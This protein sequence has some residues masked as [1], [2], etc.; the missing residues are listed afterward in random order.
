MS[1]TTSTTPPLPLLSATVISARFFLRLSHTLEYKLNS[2]NR[3]Y[4]GD[5]VD[6]IKSHNATVRFTSSYFLN[7]STQSFQSV[8]RRQDADEVIATGVGQHHSS[9][10]WAMSKHL[11]EVVRAMDTPACGLARGPCTAPQPPRSNDAVAEN[12]GG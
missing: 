6:F 3:V 8:M 1:T 11:G 5:R 12:R 9:H 10:C 4:K 2:P 7:T